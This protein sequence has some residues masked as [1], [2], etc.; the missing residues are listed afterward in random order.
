MYAES[1]FFDLAEAYLEEVNCLAAD[2]NPVT[3]NC[4]EFVEELLC[5]AT[6]C[7]GPVPTFGDQVKSTVFGILRI[8]TLALVYILLLVFFL[9]DLSFLI[10]YF[11]LPAGN[12]WLDDILNKV[13]FLFE[14][15]IKAPQAAESF[16]EDVGRYLMR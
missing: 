2:Y 13:Q 15:I 12:I 7:Y 11:D 14:D 1:F 5:A 9:I 6:G 4:Q 8:G 16:E 10:V 3:D